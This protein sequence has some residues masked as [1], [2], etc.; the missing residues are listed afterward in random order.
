M[1]DLVAAFEE[2]QGPYHTILDERGHQ[3]VLDR[4]KVDQNGQRILKRYR[5]ASDRSEDLKGLPSEMSQQQWFDPANT[6]V[7]VGREN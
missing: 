4:R 7:Q 2:H 5:I 1:K 3:I 6:M